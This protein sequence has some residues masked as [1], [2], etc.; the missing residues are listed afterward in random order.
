MGENAEITLHRRHRTVR[1]AVAIAATICLFPGTRADAQ[2]VLPVNS[3]AALVSA[4]TT[5]DQNPGTRYEINITSNVTLTAGTTLPA[6][7]TT[8][9]LIINGNN[10]TINGSGVQRGL[11]VYSG[12]VAINNLAV[13]NAAALGGNSSIGGAAG[14]GMGA[15]GALFVASGGNV[16]VSNVKLSGNSST[17]GNGGA[18]GGLGGGGG[19]LGGNGGNTCCGS[20]GG[21]VGLGANGGNGIATAGAAGIVVGATGGGAGTGGAAS[22]GANGGGGGGNAAAGGGGGVGGGNANGSSGGNGGFGGGGGGGP[23]AGGN[24]GFGGGGGGTELT[25]GAGG[26]G[27]GGANG[28]TGGSGGFGGG[29]GGSGIF[30]GG[31]G[32]GA[33]MGGA[34]FVQAGGTLTLA[35]SL[36]ING[37]SVAGGFGGGAG[38]TNG[39]AFG[40]G[41]FMQG[42][43]AITFT[44]GTGL[45]QTVS[46]VIADEKG[47]V[48]AGY[49][50]PTGFTPGSW[51][52]TLNGPGLLTLSAVNMYTGATNV[53][54]GTLNVTGSIADSSLTTVDGGAFLTG[55]GS[56]GSVKIN[57]GGTFVPGALGAPG[58][59]MTVSGNLAFAS[60]AIYL[61]QFNPS[62][63][64]MATVR[65][66]ATLTGA[67]VDAQFAP[68][69]YVIK[70]YDI[71]HAAGGVN[72]TFVSLV[73]TGL[74]SGLTDSLSY[75][76][77]DAFLTLNA[78]LA[79]VA[80]LTINE[81]NVATALDNYFNSG[82]ALPPAFAGLFGLTGTALANTLM[83]LDGEV[84]TGSEIPAF[85][86][87]NEFLDLMLDPFV[88][89]RLGSSAGFGGG[90]AL[91]F[92]PD[93]ESTLPP[94]VALAYAGVLKAPPAP[95]FQQ[96]WTAW[97]ASYGGAN[98]TAGDPAVVGSS[99]LTAETFGFAAG[100]DYHYSP[101]TI[102]GFALGG[103]GTDWGLA[104]G[105]GTGRS[106]AFQTGVYGI[107]R[108]GP[109]YLG[110]ALA[111]ANHWMSTNRATMGDILNASFDA[112]S[113]GGRIEGGYRFAVLPT[114]GVS[115]YA[116]VQ[117]QAF[118][119]P[120][121]G[122]T[123][124]TGGGL[125]LS[126][127]A[128]TAT[129][130]RTELGARF[131]DPAVV[132][133]IPVLLRGRLAW[134]HD[135]VSDPA[136]SA[137]F[138]SLPG[139]NFVVNGA[140]IPHDS[141]LTTAGAE[142]FFT[143][144]WT[145][146]VKFD[147]EFAPGSQTYAGSGTLRYVW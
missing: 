21:G 141:A 108:A 29:H 147:G 99:N 74:P 83:H 101:D 13:V 131:D 9:P 111:F 32:G 49:T 24:G 56:V 87:M 89:G 3:A 57:S 35:G 130:T 84:A 12:T 11:F 97:A 23:V 90:P 88:D 42:S 79:S 139:T 126:Y 107:T 33:G 81:R 135:F 40:T 138:E 18:A 41:I 80:G 140:P 10:F 2:V 144:R 16:T 38:G 17:G 28:I 98:S 92:A 27:G 109:A 54:A 119:T 8:S 6:I 7:N 15:G 146:L 121:Y 100:M 64:T 136:L 75:S 145:F 127:A 69:G 70:Q 30:T 96:R 124:V 120:N 132:A 53:M 93:A 123:D 125:G 105:M 95:P 59:K 104:G 112:Q 45:T 114:L 71:L 26:Y 47:I 34:V 116:A 133:G 77:T 102:V 31:G 73:N 129:D 51:G 122:E 62:T 134:A 118:H 52:L 4:L 20:G 48:L 66:T 61:V 85:Q 86:L 113:Y 76:G 22:G 5:V 103:A 37:N 50:P 39:S 78:G 14:G 67:T 36:S 143:P 58:T 65:G 128:M 115:P 44:P 25:A 110:G 55:T 19:G 72:G 94:D 91:S 137:A 82:G 106:Q 63:S 46:D 117:A 142:F 43:G 68:G 1:W 60:G